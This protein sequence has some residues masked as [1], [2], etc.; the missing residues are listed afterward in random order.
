M[1]SSQPQCT[2]YLTTASPLA[3]TWEANWGMAR[4]RM[5][6]AGMSLCTIRID[7]ASE[8]PTQPHVNQ[9]KADSAEVPS[10]HHSHARSTKSQTLA[11]G[12]THAGCSQLSNRVRVGM[13]KHCRPPQSQHPRNTSFRG[14]HM[15][16][17][18]LD[19]VNL[20]SRQRLWLRKL[21]CPKWPL[22][23]TPPSRTAK[24]QSPKASCAGR[25]ARGGDRM[26]RR[27][28]VVRARRCS[29][30]GQWLRE[31]S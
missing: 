26:H 6:H 9:P 13:T 7:D 24:K 14:E 16:A 27:S 1:C 10:H 2:R 15:P 21:V 12:E 17:S 8:R 18:L 28:R 30:S 29:T 3:P 31:A 20:I 5:E 4:M 23:R 25:S 11:L 22:P 19:G